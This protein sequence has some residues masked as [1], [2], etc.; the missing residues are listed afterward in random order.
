MSIDRN[1]DELKGTDGIK[2]NQYQCCSVAKSS[3]RLL[4]PV[5]EMHTGRKAPI[6]VFIVHHLTL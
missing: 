2:M 5:Q 3:T 4:A 6:S 1:T